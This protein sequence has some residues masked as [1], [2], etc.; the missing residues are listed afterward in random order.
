MRL[1]SIL[2]QSWW[3]RTALLKAWE[4]NRHVN[5][6]YKRWEVFLESDKG[7]V[8]MGL[9]AKTQTVQHALWMAWDAQQIM[10]TMEHLAWEPS[11]E[12][13]LN[14]SRAGCLYFMGFFS[15]YAYASS[16]ITSIFPHVFLPPFFLQGPSDFSILKVWFLLP[17][18]FLLP[19]FL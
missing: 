6:L 10:H 9:S 11:T 7:E 2:G 8:V 13:F 12:A 3:W 16:I 4:R 14:L 15:P 1:T 17:K 5:V 19:I 18:W